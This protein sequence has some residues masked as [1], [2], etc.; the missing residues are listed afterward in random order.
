[1]KYIFNNG[2]IISHSLFNT[3]DHSDGALN[4]VSLA[5]PVNDFSETGSGD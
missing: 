4:L 1:M 5:E 3:D 2:N